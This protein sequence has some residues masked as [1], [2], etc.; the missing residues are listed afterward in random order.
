MAPSTS[1]PGNIGFYL[2]LITFFSLFLFLAGIRAAVMLRAKPEDRLGTLDDIIER[3][4]TMPGR[5]AAS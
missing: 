3:L 4:M 5:L 1:F 2:A